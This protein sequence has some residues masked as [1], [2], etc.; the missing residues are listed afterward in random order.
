LGKLHSGEIGGSPTTT[1]KA[2]ADAPPR[3][4][5]RVALTPLGVMALKEARYYWRDPRHKAMLIIPLFPLAWV[6]VMSRNQMGGA[7][8]SPVSGTVFVAM[9]VL[10]SFSQLFHN[11]FGIDR[12]GLRLLFVTPCSREKILMGKNAAAVAVAGLTTSVATLVGSLAFK[13]PALGLAMAPVI[14]ASAII[15]AAIGN[16]TS[17]FFPMRMTRK[18]ENP[19]TSSSSKGCMAALVG[20]VAMLVTMIVAAPIVAAVGVALAL[21]QPWIFAIAIPGSFAY[22]VAVYMV[23]LKKVASPA[24]MTRETNI[25]EECLT[26]EPT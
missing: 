25:L 15:F 3:L 17:V 20:M 7:F 24:L 1:A 22:A 11:I 12:E 14:L 26:G 13:Q 10:M 16:L 5:Q 21:H 18:G 9:M 19:F 4:L 6:Y 2:K 8:T 23:L